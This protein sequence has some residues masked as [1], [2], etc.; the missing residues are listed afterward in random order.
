MSAIEW[1]Q[2]GL[3]LSPNDRFAPAYQ[4]TLDHAG[5]RYALA[6]VI[7][8]AALR[9][10]DVLL[11]CGCGELSP[12]ETQVLTRWVANGGQ[13]VVSGCSFGIGSLLGLK[14]AGVHLSHGRLL[15][16]ADGTLWPEGIK[17]IRFFGAKLHEVENGKARA[18]IGTR[19]AGL[20]QH[21][22]GSG[23]TFFLAPHLGQTAETMQLG[24]S[25][26]ADGIGPIDGTARLDDGILRAEDGIALD[27]SQDR[28]TADGSPIPIFATPHADALRDLWLRTT[29]EAL[30]R[31][32]KAFTVLW[33]WP[34]GAT[35]TAMITF[36]GDH[37]EGENTKLLSRVVA[38]L[39]ARAGWLTTSPGFS[40]DVYKALKSVDHDAG[41]LFTAESL[42]DWDGDKV[43]VEHLAITRAS[44]QPN[45]GAVRPGDGAWYRHRLFYEMLERIGPRL[46]LSKGGRQ[47]GTQGFPF[48]MCRPYRPL[49]LDGTP[50]QSYELGYHALMPGFPD[51]AADAIVRTCARL[52]GCFH[53]SGPTDRAENPAYLASIQRILAIIKE[54][55]LRFIVPTELLEFEEA[56]RALRMQMRHDVKSTEFVFTSATPVEG[57]TLLIYGVDDP[58]TIA[59]GAR[60]N[61]ETV[62]RY[63][64]PF[65][66]IQFDI[67]AK[68]PLSVSVSGLPQAA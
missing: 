33:H 32:R 24:R 6:E 30:K 41:L 66:Q 65:W 4:E 17:D 19:L 29:L 64:L 38:S 26:E 11:L 16:A 68:T 60:A 28:T 34:K 20:V 2:L 23:T 47:P 7:D 22:T 52:H 53:L 42:A 55:K 49:Q 59:G 15:P 37:S 1:A 27:F 54:N 62:R 63:G 8:D 13:L 21:D 43:K 3:Y 14:G 46:S 36:E 61:G 31:T 10:F 67:E 50:Y 35:G 40:A 39:G 25:V 5:V 51:A 18:T 12:V 48:G 56:R 57:L 58:Q 44:G 45:V 9:A